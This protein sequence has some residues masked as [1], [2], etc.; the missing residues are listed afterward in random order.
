MCNLDYKIHKDWQLIVCKPTHD[1]SFEQLFEHLQTLITDKQFSPGLNGLYDFCQV[2][3]VSGDLTALL[4]TAKNME[5]RNI[6]T[7]QANVAI[8]VKS[9]DC[10]LYKIFKGY[11]LMA[12]NSLVNYRLF[13]RDQTVD[14]ADF[15]N[16]SIDELANLSN[17]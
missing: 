11:C 3:H 2:D 13:S 7:D 12:S 9:E 16:L 1:F 5:N 6:I 4:Q 10:A 15:I 14:I 17:V 8:V